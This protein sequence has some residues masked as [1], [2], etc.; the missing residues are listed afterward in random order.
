MCSEEGISHIRGSRN[1][2]RELWK[3]SVIFRMEENVLTEGCKN[4]FTDHV[5]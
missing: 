4:K 1:I 2:V 3:G 5:V